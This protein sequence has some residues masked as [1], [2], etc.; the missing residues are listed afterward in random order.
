[1]DENY[2]LAACRYVELNPV[3]ANM[4]K[5]PEDY[6]WSSARAHL[7]GEDDELVKVKPMLDRTLNWEELL[8]SG[9]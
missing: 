6:K 9:D 2:L 5:R 4:V 3:R 8:A 7:M 1:M